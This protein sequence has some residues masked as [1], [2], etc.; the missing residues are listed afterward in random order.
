MNI[1]NEHLPAI[2]SA[3][4]KEQRSQTS[5]A[6]AYLRDITRL[7]RPK[8]TEAKKEDARKRAAEHQRVADI[9]TAAINAL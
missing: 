4:L 2:Q 5:L 3:L 6:K 1:P 7:H 8:W 9:T